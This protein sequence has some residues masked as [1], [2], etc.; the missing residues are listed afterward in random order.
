LNLG[1]V[2]FCVN[3][4]TRKYFSYFPVFVCKKFIVEIFFMC[5]FTVKYFTEK[6]YRW[7]IFYNQPSNLIHLLKNI[8]CSWSFI[9]YFKNSNP[10]IISFNHFN[11]HILFHH[12]HESPSPLP[13]SSHHHFLHHY[14]LT[15]TT[16]EK[17]FTCKLF[18]GKIFF[19]SNIK[20][21]FTCKIFYGKIYSTK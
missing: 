8:F 19:K 13:L 4:F 20:K 9:K 6:T 21:Y 15:T 2:C 5:L 16:I 11:H 7:K 14:H 3:Y 1:Y 17:C 12:C 18:Y 10:L